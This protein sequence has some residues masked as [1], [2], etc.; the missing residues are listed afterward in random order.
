MHELAARE[1]ATTSVGLL[2]DFTYRIDAK[3][4]VL[5]TLASGGLVRDTG[6]KVYAS[7]NNQNAAQI[8]ASYARAKWGKGVREKG[9][10]HYEKASAPPISLDVT[11][12]QRRADSIEIE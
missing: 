5:F 3:G 12:S 9:R 8:A 1:T 6:E 10:G 2:K 11:R 7:A 4:A